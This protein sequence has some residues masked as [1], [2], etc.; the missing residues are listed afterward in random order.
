LIDHKL[1]ALT[2]LAER[3]SI[4]QISARLAHLPKHNYRKLNVDN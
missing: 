2:V 3:L 4:H 1:E